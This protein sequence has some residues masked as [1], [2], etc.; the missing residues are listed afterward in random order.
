MQMNH[1]E[2]SSSSGIS[3]DPQALF[4]E[5]VAN[6]DYEGLSRLYA[7]QA[8]NAILSFLAMRHRWTQNSRHN[9]NNNNGLEGAPSARFG[10]FPKNS[11][12]K[13]KI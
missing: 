1:C 12:Q 11:V 3:V 2:N 4:F 8:R 9:N 6:K 10:T 5:H 13:K 7:F